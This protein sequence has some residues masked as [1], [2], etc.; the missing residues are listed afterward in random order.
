VSVI[1]APYSSDGMT[2]TVKDQ[3]THRKAYPIATSS[4]TYDTIYDMI[5][6]CQLQMGWHPV[7]LVQHTFTHKQNTEQHN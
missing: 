3:S 2:L 4:P 5:Y 1:V 7:P 6:I